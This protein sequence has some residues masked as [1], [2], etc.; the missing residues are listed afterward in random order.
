MSPQQRMDSA[1]GRSDIQSY[2]EALQQTTRRYEGLMQVLSI[3]REMDEVDD[4]SSELGEI[5]CRILEIIAS[6]L[7]AENCSLFLL[8]EGGEFLSLRAACSAF[9][10][11]STFFEPDT[12][13]VAKFHLGEGIIGT[14]AQRRQAIRVEDTAQ[15]ENFVPIAASRVEARSLLCFPLVVAEKLVGV[16]N[17]SHS[18]PGFFSAQSENTLSF[19]AERAARIFASHLL[20]Q[21]VR[22]SEEHYRLVAKNAGDGILVFDKDGHLVSA[23]PAVET[24]SGVPAERYLSGEADWESGIHPADRD[25]FM[26]HQKQLLNAETPNT[27][28]Y[29]HL[30]AQG[31][32][33][34]LEQRS[35]P[36]LDSSGHVTGIVSVARDITERKRAEENRRELE[37]QL[38]HVQKLES[39]GVLAGGI[40]HDFNNLLVG[41]M[42]NAD[43]AM[44]EITPDSPARPY[45]EKI[46]ATGRR[47]A[48]LT[49]EMLAYSG[50]GTFVIE[51]LHLGKLAEAIGQLLEASI[52]KTAV[53]KCDS[54]P[55]LPLIKGDAS[56]LQQVIMN[57]ITNASDA[58]GDHPGVITVSIKSMEADRTY[59]S[60]T[61]LNDGLEKG[62][63]VCL[64]VSDTGCGMD[65]DVRARA[66]EPFFSTKFAGRGLGLAAVLGIIRGHKGAIKVYSEPGQ[67]T[68]FKVLF[69][70]ITHGEEGPRRE[71]APK[72][73]ALAGW[74]GS[75]AVLIA[76]DEEAVR[77]VAQSISEEHGFTVLTA[78]DGRQAVE[79]FHQHSGE[80][81]LVLLDLTMP[82]MSGVEAFE[83]IHGMR[84]DI[85]IILSS[86]FSKQELTGRFL[87]KGP[88]AF[89]QKPYS[90]TEL[91]TKF[92]HVLQT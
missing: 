9:E 39:L 48:D 42:G 74:R 52:S 18:T 10:A 32:V 41:V 58:I 44:L 70:A 61:Y 57:L 84:P 46:E 28:Q 83:K 21:R 77:D 56:Q 19:V 54:E 64:E 60:K 25:L 37:E 66:F 11:Q 73:E 17:L 75:G 24:I 40:A 87:G 4:P 78:G 15:D 36:L 53:L 59:L 68:T 34:H 5:C 47:A 31:E 12:W 33:H 82:V 43:L 80:I 38:Q 92:R 69:P 79:I 7:A 30:D 88:A 35:S 81:K 20:H 13:S 23:N 91:V 86:G 8:D 62:R 49:R 55:D 72:E 45:I 65:D 50:K 90:A 76:D 85:P 51:P 1:G 29:R 6:G 63:Y 22:E 3:L 27:I 14:V 67:G 2:V 26:A 16:L 89:I 71:A